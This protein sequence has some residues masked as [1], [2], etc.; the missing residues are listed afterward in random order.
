[1]KESRMIEKIL[2]KIDEKQSI[3]SAKQISMALEQKIQ[4][5]FELN[6]IY[7]SNAIEGNTL[8]LQETKVVL[9][10]ITIGGKSLREHFE[11]INHKE[12]IAYIKDIVKNKEDLSQWQIKAIHSLILK[13]IDND[14]AGKYR[15]ANVKISGAKHIPTDYLKINDEMDS[16][17]SYYQKDAQKLHP[18]IRASRVHIHFVG[19]HP[20]IDG[21]G[22]T[23]RLLMNLELLKNNLLPIN[24]KNENKLEYYQALDMAH[25][26]KDY[27]RFDLL[28]AEYVLRAYEE[29][30]AL[31]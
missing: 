25:C 6:Y 24:I 14:N 2:S 26:Q 21:N 30:M 11:V 17:I 28:I 31:L 20:F 10:G 23:A 4:E 22:R 9:E 16:F 7:D 1:M 15:N 12:A 3:L 18:V 8:T 19:I 27:S 13:N 29:K 5:D